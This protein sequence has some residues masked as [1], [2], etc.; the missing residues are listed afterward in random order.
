MTSDSSAAAFS[1]GPV[2][3]QASFP[4]G[5][6]LFDEGRFEAA[7]EAFDA[8]A[9]SHPR[10]AA[11]WYNLG[12]AYHRAGHP[13]YAVWGWLRALELEPRDADT[14][15][16]LRVVGVPENLSRARL[17][18]ARAVQIVLRNGLKILGVE[19]PDRMERED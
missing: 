8:H 6:A 11:A 5:L 17:V 9:R 18:L 4:D 15:H 12:T 1:A 16:N 7:A 19:A 3:G 13:G 10:D 2:R 14:R